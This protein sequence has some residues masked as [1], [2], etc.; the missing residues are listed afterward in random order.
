MAADLKGR[1]ADLQDRLASATRRNLELEAALEQLTWTAARG[2]ARFHELFKNMLD[3][4]ALHEIVL[5]ARGVPVDYRFLAVN[6]AF[7]RQTGLLGKDILGRLV[8]EVLPGIEPVWIE[9]YGRVALTGEPVHFEQFAET[10]GL[11]FEV[12]AYRPAPGRFACLFHDI[13]GRKRAEEARHALQQQIQQAQKLESVG[14]LAGGIAHDFNNLLV[15]IMGNAE[16]ALLDLAPEAPARERLNA[17]VT[18]SVRAAE[19]V[20]Q[21]LAYSGRGRFV[22]EPVDVAALVREMGHLLQVSVSKKASLKLDLPEGLPTVQADA[23][24]L[25][26]LTMNLI[27]NA[28]D[29]LQDGDGVIALRCGAMRCDRAYLAAAF[30]DEDLPAGPYLWLEVSDTG[31]GMDAQTQA[32]I[33]DPFFSTKFA[34][35]GLGLAAALGIVRGHKGAIRVYS[36]PGVGTTFKVLLPTCDSEAPPAETAETSDGDLLRG[37][38]VLLVD[39]EASVREVCGQMLRRMGLEVV[40]AVD[41]AEAVACFERRHADIDCVLLDLTMPQVDGAECFGALRR[42]KPEVRVVLASG[43][44]EQEVISRFAGKGLAG[45]IQKPYL[46]EHL[47]NRLREV[48]SV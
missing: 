26:Q 11:H 43:Y 41:G 46:Y 29:A 44:N 22:I 14:V 15:G 20:R 16:L 5:D 6:P 48:F 12:T 19:L 18:A 2:G 25:R 30:I 17:V 35:R 4:F 10:L 39:D 7:E 31:K 13:T 33:F 28:S 21:L 9:T 3:G 45:F 37:K 34:G 38:R 40:L 27:T 47:S 36:E 32:R 42:I 24:Q 8:T 23:T 1:V